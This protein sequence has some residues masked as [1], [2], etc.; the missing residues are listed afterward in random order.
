MD[1]QQT[2][3]ELLAT[4]MTQQQLADRVMCSQSLIAAFVNGTRGKQPSL[5]IGVRVIELHAEICGG[6]GEQHA[7]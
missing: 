4:G 1:I 7:D 3:I 5:N 6:K 2:V